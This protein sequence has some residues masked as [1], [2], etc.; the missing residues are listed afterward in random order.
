M[1]KLAAVIAITA[2]L[3]SPA[4]AQSTYNWN[5]GE[6]K[7]TRQMNMNDGSV[8][9]SRGLFTD[10]DP[11]IRGSFQRNYNEYQNLNN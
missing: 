3:A 11:F 8:L 4:L 2:A 9:T 10:P 6:Y 7:Q 5:T 1:K